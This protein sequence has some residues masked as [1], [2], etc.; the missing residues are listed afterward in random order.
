[1]TRTKKVK[2]LICSKEVYEGSDYKYHFLIYHSNKAERK[3]EFKYYCE[4]CDFGSF[5]ETKYLL[6]LKSKKHQK[7]FLPQH[8]CLL[9]SFMSDAESELKFHILKEHA[10][11]NERKK[12]A[13]WYCLDCDTMMEGQVQYDKHFASHKHQSTVLLNQQQ[14]NH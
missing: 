12:H 5:S 7:K 13:Q 1:M 8:R 14:K 11:E 9:C 4:D 3:E 6:H 10:S 2:C